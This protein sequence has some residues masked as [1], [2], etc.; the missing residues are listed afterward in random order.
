[1]ESDSV[2]NLL[3]QWAEERPG[4]DLGG[5]GVAVRI[6]RLAHFLSSRAD[7]ALAEVGLSLWEYD[8]LSALCRQGHPFRLPASHLARE[9]LT[10]TGAITNRVDRLIE[11]GLVTRER[12]E[13]DRRAV[14][15][16][17]SA[18]GRQVIADA[19]ETRVADTDDSLEGLTA[20]ERQALSSRLRSLLA[21]VEAANAAE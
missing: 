19:I 21:Q 9:T 16:R 17:L 10:S 6:G 20:H 13:N 4:L 11:K 14:L 3:I 5:L 18:K 2:D 7:R 15:V 8:V 1:M 12:D